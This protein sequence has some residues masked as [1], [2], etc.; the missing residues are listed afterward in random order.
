MKKVRGSL[1]ADGGVEES[2]NE[3]SENSDEKSSELSD[4]ML[5]TGSIPEEE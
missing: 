5:E 3:R 4:F 1:E 2:E